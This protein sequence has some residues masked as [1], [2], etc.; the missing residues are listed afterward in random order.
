M[1]T[2]GH[3]KG[4]GHV[5]G[6]TDQGGAMRA[7]LEECDRCKGHGEVCATCEGKG[8]RHRVPDGFNAFSAGGWNTIN[9]MY[10]IPCGDCPASDVA[11]K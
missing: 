8:Y 1:I 6:Y 2:C 5:A 10:R 9:A 4:K 3:C 7:V 11:D